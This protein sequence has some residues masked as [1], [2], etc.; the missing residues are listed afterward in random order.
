MILRNLDIDE[1]HAHQAVSSSK[2]KTIRSKGFGDFKLRYIDRVLPKIDTKALLIG[3]AFDKKFF[4]GD[5]AFFRE[6]SVKPEGLDLTTKA[7][8]AWKEE[9]PGPRISAEEYADFCAMENEIRAHP[10]AALL[11][12]AGEPQVSIRRHS[13]QYGFEIQTRPD[14]LAITPPPGVQNKYILDLKTTVDFSLWFDPFDPLAP[15]NGSPV[16]KFGYHKQA[17][18]A[19]W[20][21]AQEEEIGKTDHFLL[22]VEK[23]LPYRVGVIQLDEEYLAIGWNSV[24]RDLMMLSRAYER[25]EWPSSPTGIIKL[26]PPAFLDQ[27]EAREYDAAS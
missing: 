1:Y 19:Q 15:F 5:E 27:K 24:Q 21:A 3:R 26:F 23:Q 11:L 16:W 13:T 4:D 10:D 18:L 6:F 25:D 14:W 20:L 12:S 17:A 8:R 2:L 22:V 7:G 9:N